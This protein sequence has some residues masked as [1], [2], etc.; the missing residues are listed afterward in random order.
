LANLISDKVFIQD[1]GI[2]AFK[3][4]YFAQFWV[5][6]RVKKLFYHRCKSLIF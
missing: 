3:K 5:T 2:K 4:F 1:I 6:I